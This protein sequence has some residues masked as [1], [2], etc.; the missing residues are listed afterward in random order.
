MRRLGPLAFGLV[1]GGFLVLA[2][3]PDDDPLAGSIFGLPVALG[4]MVWGLAVATL[5]ILG[6]VYAVSFPRWRPGGER[7]DEIREV[8]RSDPRRRVSDGAGEGD[9]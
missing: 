5:M 7:L 4:V 6:L 3:L 8:A 1:V 2:S 9:G